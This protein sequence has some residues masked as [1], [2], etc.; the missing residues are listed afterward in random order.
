MESFD[1]FDLK[2]LTEVQHD[3][4]ITAA[5][6]AEKVHLSASQCSRRL[7]RLEG[8]GVIDHYT[9]VLNRDRLNLDVVAYVMVTLRSHSAQNL[10]GFRS[11]IMG[12]P[13]VLD[14]AKITGDADYMLKVITTDL[15]R[16]N[17]ILTEKLMRAEEVAMVRSSIVLQEL[18]STSQ[19][20]LPSLEILNG[21]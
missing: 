21:G 16:Y 18:K 2:I 5:R 14:C 17:D 9:A 10:E 12:L 11:L 7:Q 8:L 19:M 1:D 20:P 3:G 4:A 15:A 13:E 6:L